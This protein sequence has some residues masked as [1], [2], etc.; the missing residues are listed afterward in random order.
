MSDID[1]L[2]A[3]WLAGPLD[4]TDAW[5]LRHML[6]DPAARRRW[7]ELADLEGALV[8]RGVTTAAAPERTS[9]ISARRF[10]ITPVHRCPHWWIAV[11]ASV[12]F[13][14]GAGWW[15][16]Q[17]DPDLPRRDGR[18]LSRGELVT[19]PAV[20][21]WMDGTEAWLLSGGSGRVPAAGK[22]LDIDVGEVAVQA[23]H[24]IGDNRFS[25]RSI[26]A[27]AR[28][29]GTRFS[30]RCDARSTSLL[31]EEGEV[32]FAPAG[33]AERRVLR[34]EGALA[35]KG[36]SPGAGLV[37]WWPLDE[38]SG[39]VAHDRSGQGHD[40]RIVGPRWMADGLHFGGDDQRVDIQPDGAL[41]TVQATDY[42]IAAWFRPDALPPPGE[43]KDP[44]RSRDMFS[45]I[46]GRTGWTLGLHLDESGRFFMEHFLADHSAQLARSSTI[47]TLHR[48]HHLVGVVDQVRGET[49]VAVDG[50]VVGREAWTPGS[51]TC[52]YRRTHLWRIGIGDPGN[53][54]CRWPARGI[55]RDVRI[56][57]RALD[58]H[59]I[60][61]LAGSR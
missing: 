39:T 47:A 42:S 58:G 3:A 40:G 56:Y 16:A 48:W 30:L 34:G 22:G 51:A 21:R 6:N 50:V 55:I 27:L 26:H 41:A 52:T 33:G 43:I 37:G 10:Q 45:V 25:V 35:G 24:Q 14:L 7:R 20:L 17:V 4:Q 2:F 60:L 31:V 29:V 32:D 61:R 44:A 13:A 12:L 23:T 28:V 15:S 1:R 36:E 53:P 49:R 46:A 11:A 9:P 18:L 38:A 59:D 19:G 54:T 8:E 57:D 5:R